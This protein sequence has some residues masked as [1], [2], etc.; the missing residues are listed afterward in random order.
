MQYYHCLDFECIGW[1][2]ERRWKAVNS[3]KSE[4][5]AQNL[6]LVGT[7]NNHFC[8]NSWNLWILK[9]ECN[10]CAHGWSFFTELRNGGDSQTKHIQNMLLQNFLGANLH[11]ELK[12][13]IIYWTLASKH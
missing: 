10:S 11:S 5:K 7:G 9:V 2:V 1:L 4:I 12:P 6:K 8:G 3:M 13:D